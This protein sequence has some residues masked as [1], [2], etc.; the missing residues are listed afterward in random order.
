M[1]RTTALAVQ[2]IIA[3]DTT[4]A[5]ITPFIEAAG[6][7]VTD[8]C[9][10]SSYDTVKLELIERWLAAHFYA[11]R[12]PL[13]TSQGAGGASGSFQGQTGMF[14]QFTSYGQMACLL[15]TDGNLANLDLQMQKGKYKI[16]M[17]MIGEI[18]DGAARKYP[19]SEVWG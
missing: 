8:V 11:V 19:I 16:T 3:T 15:D 4:I 12:D 18:D 2:G 9:L 10:D 6:S 7:I 1:A 5:D 13:L 17:K 14:L